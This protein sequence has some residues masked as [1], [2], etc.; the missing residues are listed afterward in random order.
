MRRVPSGHAS[1]LSEDQH[2]RQSV[3][4]QVPVHAPGTPDASA[5]CLLA[6]NA[7]MKAIRCRVSAHPRPGPIECRMAA[8]GAGRFR[9]RSRRLRDHVGSLDRCASD[10]R[11]MTP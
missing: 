10:G 3:V 1:R 8:A 11:E 7:D 5:G 9:T 2:A 4:C 6:E